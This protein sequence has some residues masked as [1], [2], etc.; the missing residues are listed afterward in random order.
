[1]TKAKLLTKFA[2]VN[3]LYY[4]DPPASPPVSPPPVSPPPASPPVSPPPASGKVFTQD[5]VNKLMEDHRKNLQNQNKELITQLEELRNN[6]NLTAQEKENL[7]ARIDTL[8]QQHLTKDQQNQEAYAK[9]QKKYESDT[10]NLK[11]AEATWKTRFEGVMVDNAIALGAN[12]HNARS[13]KQLQMM[14]KNQAKVV[15]V[16]GDDGKPTGV[17]EAR[18]PVEVTDPKTKQKATVELAVQDAIGKLRE[19]DEFANLF[20]TDVKSGFGGGNYNSG[21]SGNGSTPDFSKMTPDE[22]AEWRKKQTTQR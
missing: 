16:V 8:S 21:A 10:K 3:K 6:N 7:Q 17:W 5:E 2:T 19:I 15:E 14:F 18:M 20:N 11:E 22:Y 4:N 1:M 12:Q 13:A 9:L